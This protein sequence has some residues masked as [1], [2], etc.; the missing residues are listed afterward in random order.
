MAAYDVPQIA[1]LGCRDGPSVWSHSQAVFAA[2]GSVVGYSG[3]SRPG[4]GG[5]SGY[6]RIAGDTVNRL[7]WSWLARMKR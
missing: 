1:A 7:G 6:F 4:S 3:I 2:G 5:D